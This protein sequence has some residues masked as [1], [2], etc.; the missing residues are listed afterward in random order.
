MP[1]FAAEWWD[2]RDLGNAAGS[3]L[4]WVDDQGGPGW[5]PYVVS[6]LI[7]VLA[8]LTWAL[9]SQLGFVWIERRLIGRMQVRLGPNRVGPF[10][11]LQPLADAIKVLTKEMITPR[12]ADRWLYWAAPL[13]VM[14]PALVVFAVVPFGEHMV[15]ADLNVGLLFVIAIS[16]V[17][18]LI[19]FTAGWSSAN[20]YSL[21]GA[22]RVVAMLISYELIQVLA[23]LSVVI[24][25][26]SMRMGTVVGWQDHYN[27]WILFIQP[28]PVLGYALA[29][30]VEINRTPT[31]IA[32]AESEIVAGYHTEYGGIRW[33]MFQLAEYVAGFAIAAI[34]VTLFL[35]GWTLWGLEEWIPGWLIFLGKLYLYFFLF[36]WLRGTLPRLRIDQLMA[37]AWKY[38]LP[39]MLVNVLLAGLEVLIW[40]ENDLSAGLV[41]PLFAI[42][43]IGLTVAML[44]GWARLLGH[45]RPENQPKRARLVTEVG[46]IQYEPYGLPAGGSRR[47]A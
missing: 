31:D 4:G 26:N 22:M 46:S 37:F 7:G 8:I 6:G 3:F 23:V 20:K 43:N 25:T 30:A 29:G 15:L 44:V 18:S 41:M 16:S 28:L 12:N 2:I 35:G 42:V 39:L 9:L 19:V 21:L 32:E 40:Q 24:F 47:D 38:M 17:N 11:L 14:L 33:G 13:A 27:T 10:G 1:L 5:L 34:M 36:I 45:A